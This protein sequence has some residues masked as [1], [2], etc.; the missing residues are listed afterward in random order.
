VATPP[1]S[2][3]RAPVALVW[4]TGTAETQASVSL[5]DAP[6]I[7]AGRKAS[8]G[9]DLTPVRSPAAP[10]QAEPPNVDKVVDEVIRRLDRQYRVER[11]RR[12]L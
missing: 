8:A 1:A 7:S 5:F 2:R 9:I 11:M 10:P 3:S 4:P 6:Q 12:G